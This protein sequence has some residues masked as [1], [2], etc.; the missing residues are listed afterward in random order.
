MASICKE[1]DKIKTA[2]VVSKGCWQNVATSNK[3]V[4]N[5]SKGIL[6]IDPSLLEDVDSASQELGKG[7]F[8]AVLIKKI[9]VISCTRSCQVF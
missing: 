8:G 9:L 1:K 6:N 2:E 5:V 7:R 3:A 4:P